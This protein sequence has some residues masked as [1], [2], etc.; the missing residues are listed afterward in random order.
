MNKLTIDE[1]FAALT[2]ELQQTAALK[3]EIAKYQTKVEIQRN[4]INNLEQRNR[5]MVLKI[6]KFND[7]ELPTV[8]YKNSDEFVISEQIF[9]A[10]RN[11]EDA[12]EFAFILQKLRPAERFWQVM[13]SQPVASI[14]TILQCMKT[15]KGFDLI[16]SRLE[17]GKTK[18]IEGAECTG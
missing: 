17:E 5:A 7:T 12:G 15:E 6:D 13:K 3:K 2:N 10:V 4:R 8:S 11:R 16:I 18:L 14:L 1:C 9:N